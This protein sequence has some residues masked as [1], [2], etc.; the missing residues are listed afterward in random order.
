MTEYH[1]NPETG[2][3]GLCRAKKQCRFGSSNEHYSTLDEARS[4]YEKTMSQRA[5]SNNKKISKNNDDEAISLET[6]KL[7]LK[8]SKI[9]YESREIPLNGERITDTQM[10][11]SL[12]AKNLA[13]DLDRAIDLQFFHDPN[14][15]P[16][17]RILS[18]DKAV[19]NYQAEAHQ[20]IA[21]KQI[22]FLGR[23][24]AGF[25]ERL[26]ESNKNLAQAHEELR[27]FIK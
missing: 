15:N 11:R 4:A 9:D 24:K 14:D 8:Q 7:K 23:R 25:N 26:E 10:R 6:Q 21:L 16:S 27:Q 22:G 13:N 2:Q 3:P 1:I 19:A 20:N 5:Y 12:A 17:L 18:Y